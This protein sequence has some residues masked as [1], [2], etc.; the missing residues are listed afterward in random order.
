MPVITCIEDLRQRVAVNR[1][2]RSL[3]TT[4][5]HILDLMGKPRWRLGMARTPRHGF[6]TLTSH[7]R[8]QP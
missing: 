4:L 6:S 5:A 3:H 7:H 1:D 2:T 8:R